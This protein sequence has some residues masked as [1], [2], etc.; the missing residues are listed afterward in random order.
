MKSN[1]AQQTDLISKTNQFYTLIPH[2]FG[3]AGPNIIDNEE[4]IKLKSQM[5][6]SLLEMEIAYSLL[7]SETDE[8]KNPLDAHYEQLKTDIDTLGV[9]VHLLTFKYF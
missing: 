9:H 2:S 1:T 7:H 6:E 4:E 5:L 8:N 3:V